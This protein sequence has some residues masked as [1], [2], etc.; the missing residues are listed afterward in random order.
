MLQS[1]NDDDKMRI[2]VTNYLTAGTVV[3][4]V[5]VPEQNVEVYLPG[6]PVK[7]LSVNE[8]LD[9]SD[10]LPGFQIPVRDIFPPQPNK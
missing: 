3:W 5:N 8:T 9:G 6:K 7:I 4:V 2:K 10:V 1:A